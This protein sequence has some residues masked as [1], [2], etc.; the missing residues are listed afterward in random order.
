MAKTL[1]K[2][3]LIYLIPFIIALL[4]FF[5]FEPYDY[6]NLKGDAFYM[7]KPLSST[8]ELLLRN[9][10]NLIFGDSRMANM[11]V[12]YIEE[13]TGERYTMMAFGGATLNDA[14]N[15]FWY[16]TEHTDMK[17]VV[18]GVNFYALN[19][20]HLAD[21]FNPIVPIAENP[22]NFVSNFG[23]WYEAFENCRR[24]ATNLFYSLFGTPEK[25]IFMDDPS[26]PTQKDPV[27][28]DTY[29]EGY[30]S[31]LFDYAHIISGQVAD[32]GDPN[33]YMYE[34][35]KII[36]YCEQ[37]EVE[38]KFVI[39]PSH[40]SIWE[41]VIFEQQLQYYI[42]NYKDDLKSSAIVYD[43]EWY[44][45]YSK[46]DSNFIDGFHLSGEQKLAFTRAVFSDELDDFCVRT[47]PE[48]YLAERPTELD[49][50][51]YY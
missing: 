25:M 46:T 22:I 12:D 49:E 27:P 34:L 6:F 41:L 44:N 31:D 43:F 9:P 32:F 29:T 38:L 15:E 23:H 28:P 36:N 40:Y 1:V 17:K 10:E 51:I 7:S 42:R 24:K 48:Q 20:N 50:M 8:R 19:S 30:R 11:N 26:S 39:A 13:L 3:L 47:T 4:W 33:I 5:L 2:K 45:D 18:I 16:A 37:N 35:N 21:R 14:I